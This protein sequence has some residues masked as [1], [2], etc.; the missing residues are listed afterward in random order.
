MKNKLFYM[1]FMLIIVVL[2]SPNLYAKVEYL[3][4]IDLDNNKYHNLFRVE[5]FAD[6]NLDGVSSGDFQNTE[7]DKYLYGKNKLWLNL[8][9]T[10][11]INNSYL[12]VL[13]ID[14]TVYAKGKQNKSTWFST[15]M[16]SYT[17]TLN[18][19]DLLFSTIPSGNH[20]ILDISKNSYG[21]EIN[22]DI[23]LNENYINT[24]HITN[25]LSIY[26]QKQL[27]RVKCESSIIYAD[28]SQKRSVDIK[29]QYSGYSD[30]RST[31]CA[32]Y[33]H[34]CAM[35]VLKSK[36]SNASVKVTMNASFFKDKKLGDNYTLEANPI[37]LEVC[38]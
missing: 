29:Y 7:T 23:I 30:D 38:C 33:F 10:P 32:G 5:D 36:D 14:G 9:K 19:D 4:K 20:S 12:Y 3:D 21:N 31:P 17:I 11:T 6:V 8:I 34:Q 26:T 18:K 37:E 35:L 1:I 22:R 28:S 15:K 16:V 25:D 27:N 24:Q 2:I 13:L